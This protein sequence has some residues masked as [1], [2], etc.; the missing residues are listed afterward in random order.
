MAAATKS[1]NPHEYEQ[2]ILQRP[3]MT[4]QDVSKIIFNPIITLYLIADTKA[5]TAIGVRQFGFENIVNLKVVQIQSIL[6]AHASAC[7]LPLFMIQVSQRKLFVDGASSHIHVRYF[8]Q[9]QLN[10]QRQYTDFLCIYTS[11]QKKSTDGFSFL[12]GKATG[13][14]E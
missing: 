1:H 14:F 2:K 8:V 7:C 3:A 11:F 12:N 10:C 13:Q 5:M 4:P 6:L 9:S